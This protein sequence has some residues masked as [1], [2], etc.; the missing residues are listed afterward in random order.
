METIRINQIEP[1]R[2]EYLYRVFR[3]RGRYTWLS[4]QR[5]GTVQACCDLAGMHEHMLLQFILF[6]DPTEQARW[7]Y[8]P[9]TEALH[10]W[11]V[12]VL[13]GV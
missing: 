7:P 6:A 9:T 13:R 4:S 5:D 2:A 8:G 1:D 3:N 11:T 12:G 10:A